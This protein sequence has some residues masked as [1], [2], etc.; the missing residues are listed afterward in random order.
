M[1][2]PLVVYIGVSYWELRYFPPLAV[3]FTAA[4]YALVNIVL[5]WLA[6]RAA[7][8]SLRREGLADDSYR[9]PEF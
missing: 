5:V 3:T 8:R 2:L 4:T 9:P 6:R 7:L 1:L